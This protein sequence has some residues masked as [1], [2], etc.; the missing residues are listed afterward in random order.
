MGELGGC[1]Q[2]H[3]HSVSFFSGYGVTLAGLPSILRRV[4]IDMPG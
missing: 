1:I 3:S 4:S 2:R